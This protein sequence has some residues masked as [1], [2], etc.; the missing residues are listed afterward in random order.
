MKSSVVFVV[1]EVL[2]H[3]PCLPMVAC[4]SEETK[5]HLVSCDL[6]GGVMDNDQSESLGPT[7]GGDA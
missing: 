6:V 3:H 2:T 1:S 4:H 5:A 7:R